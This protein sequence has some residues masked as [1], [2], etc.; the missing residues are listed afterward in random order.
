MAA[1]GWVEL[2]EITLNKVSAERTP[3]TVTLRTNLGKGRIAK[4]ADT[5]N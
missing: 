3:F 5:E 2:D 4:A 1:L